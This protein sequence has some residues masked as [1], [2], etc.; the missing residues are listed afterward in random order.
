MQFILIFSIHQVAKVRQQEKLKYPPHPLSTIELEKRAS[1][2][3]RI[4][5]EQTMKVRFRN[6]AVV[7]DSFFMFSTWLNWYVEHL[8]IPITQNREYFDYKIEFFIIKKSRNV[9]LLPSFFFVFE[10]TSFQ[11]VTLKNLNSFFLYPP[12]TF[13]FQIFLI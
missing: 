2:Y 9:L 1:R 12:V 11:M 4:S 6:S 5:S 8:Y 10:T 3:F 7:F 13:F